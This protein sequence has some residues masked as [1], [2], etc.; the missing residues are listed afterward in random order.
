MSDQLSE[1]ELSDQFAAD[2]DDFANIGHS[3]M[4]ESPEQCAVHDDGSFPLYP[5]SETTVMDGALKAISL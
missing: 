5:G 1:D 3:P 2:D 4:Y